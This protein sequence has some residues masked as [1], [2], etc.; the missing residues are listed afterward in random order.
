MCGFIMFFYEYR[1]ICFDYQSPFSSPVDS[2]CLRHIEI[3]SP[4]QSRVFAFSPLPSTKYF[5][6]T[7]KAGEERRIKA[8]HDKR[9]YRPFMPSVMTGNVRSL[10]NKIDELSSLSKFHS[11]YR[12][13]SIIKLK[14]GSQRTRL[15]SIMTWMAFRCTGVIETLTQIKPVAEGSAPILT[16][17]GVIEITYIKLK[18]KPQKTLNSSH[19][20]YGPSNCLGSLPMCTS[21][22]STHLQIQTWR[23]PI[24]LSRNM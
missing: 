16:T 11:D 5:L 2:V 12:Q 10:N 1:R 3:T 17:N 22:P 18:K 9:P 15:R 6:S 4:K 20:H 21:R 13:A 19:Y 24:T 14:H 23:M 7:T 8:K